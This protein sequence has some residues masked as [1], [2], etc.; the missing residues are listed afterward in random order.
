MSVKWLV[1]GVI[2]VGAT[3]KLGVIRF[4]FR[5]GRVIEVLAQDRGARF[6]TSVS[7]YG[8]RINPSAAAY[9]KVPVLFTSRDDDPRCPINLLKDIEK[10]IVR[11]SLVIGCTCRD[12][13]SQK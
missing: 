12:P 9:V 2:V 10:S 7:F 3:K 13:S 11:G 5:N 4:C 6:G 1:D 8:T